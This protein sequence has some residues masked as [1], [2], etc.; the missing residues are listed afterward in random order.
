MAAEILAKRGGR[1]PT[2][3]VIVRQAKRGTVYAIR[4]PA[5]GERQFETLG[6][7]ADGWTRELAEDELERRMAEVKLGQYIPPR[8]PVP[9]EPGPAEE[10]T[11]REFAWRWYEGKA[12]EVAPGTAEIYRWHVNILVRRLGELPLSEITYGSVEDYKR[13]ML[14]EQKGL[15]EARE[16][17]EAIPHRPFSNETINKTLVR[18]GQI[19]AAA[20]RH[21]LVADNP[22]REEGV[23]LKAR[24]PTRSYLDSARQIEALLDGARALDAEATRYRHVGRYAMVA[25]LVFAGLRLGE[26]LSLRWRDVDLAGGWLRVKE[27]GDAKTEEGTRRVKIRP[28]LMDVLA[29]RKAACGGGPDDL[30]FATDKGKRHSQSNVRRRIVAKAAERAN[31]KLDT[32]LPKLSPHSLRRTFMSVL[33]A[34]GEPP[35][36]VMQEVGHTDPKLSLRIYAQAMRRDPEEVERLRA[37]VNGEHMAAPEQASERVER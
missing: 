4:F 11:F 37:L 5:Y 22:A 7:E 24:K 18:L 9:D 12:A 2:G 29:E 1:R 25:T 8:Q 33:Y 27:E 35:T 13:T 32:P 36:V 15:R 10:P 17:G 20:K 6:Y 16:R 26:V 34:L 28:V 14:R 21:R 23:K 31:D 3:T 30:V 19:L